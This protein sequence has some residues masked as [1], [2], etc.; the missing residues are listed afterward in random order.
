[1]Q[2][3][4]GWALDRDALFETAGVT[5]DDVSFVQTYDDYPVVSLMQL[6]DMGFLTKGDGARF[7]QETDL[8]TTGDGLPVNTSGGQ[9]SSGQAGAAGGFLGIVEGIRQLT[10]QALGDAVSNA[11]IGV[12]TGY[13]MVDYDRCLCTGAA[14]LQ[15]GGNG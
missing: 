1:M 8:T 14:I 6:E 4:G 15:R 9:L 5:H 2:F 13:G 10:D 7:L 3:R 12:V 11:R